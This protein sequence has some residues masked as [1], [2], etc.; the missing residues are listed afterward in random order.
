MS[1]FD[2]S[3]PAF[4]SKYRHAAHE[5]ESVLLST[6]EDYLSH[7]NLHKW[8][9]AAFTDNERSIMSIR[10]LAIGADDERDVLFSRNGTSPVAA[11]NKIDFLGELTY[12]FRDDI[13]VTK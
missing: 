6:L 9:T 2:R 12:W 3:W 5:S 10:F 8:W 1:R 7:F 4:T 13:S 11:W